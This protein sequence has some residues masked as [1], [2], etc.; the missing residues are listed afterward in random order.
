MGIL[1]LDSSPP[2]FPPRLTGVLSTHGQLTGT[3]QLQGVTVAAIEGPITV[4]QGD[5]AEY[6]LVVTDDAGQPFPLST[7]TAIDVRVAPVE[8]AAVLISLSLGAGVQLLDEST[9]KGH[10]VIAFGSTDTAIQPNR[11]RMNVAVTAPGLRQHVIPP[12]DLVI[13]AVV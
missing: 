9:S 6:L 11:Y 1:L 10:A 5:T 3:L 8:G 13:A 12:R 7:A 4:F 2:A